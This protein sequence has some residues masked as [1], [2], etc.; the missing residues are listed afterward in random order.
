MESDKNLPDGSNPHGVSNSILT[1]SKELSGRYLGSA[2]MVA[3]PEVTP[4][5]SKSREA[6]LSE[7][8]RVYARLAPRARTF[9]IFGG[10]V[11][12][13]KPRPPSGS[14]YG[15]WFAGGFVVTMAFVRVVRS[16]RG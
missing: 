12:G 5:L 9:K 15:D 16:L 4:D 3:K 10:R 11:P 14:L 1:E 13:L 6:G 8:R 2:W 7:V